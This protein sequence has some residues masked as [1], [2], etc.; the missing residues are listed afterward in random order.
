MKNIMSNT[1]S[2]KINCTIYLFLFLFSTGI[3]AQNKDEIKFDSIEF[4]IVFQKNTTDYELNHYVDELK[5]H[6]IAFEIQLK[7]RNT[8]GLLIELVMNFKTQN[9]LEGKSKQIRTIPIRKVFLNVK[10]FVDGTHE[11]GFFDNKLF[12]IR[13]FDQNI[14]E[15]ISMIENIRDNA[16]I[17]IDDILSNKFELENLDVYAINTIE[18]FN[19]SETL[20]KYNAVKNKEIVIVTLNKFDF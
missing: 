7:K 10:K 3:I 19:D 2:Q 5:R 17:Y 4:T 1:F 14:E 11:I 13:P 20:K 9:G 16:V 15:K 8:K 12:Q 18:I 6:N